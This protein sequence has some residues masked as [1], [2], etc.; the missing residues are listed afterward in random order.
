MNKGQ[1]CAISIF[2]EWYD[3]VQL[4]QRRMVRL[5]AGEATQPYALMMGRT[6]NR[7]SKDIL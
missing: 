5:R 1:M 4:H 3:G 7:V 2:Q 6:T